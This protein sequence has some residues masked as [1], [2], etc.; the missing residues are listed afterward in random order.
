MKY[1]KFFHKKRKY[2][3]GDYVRL[4]R[5]KLSSDI[6]EINTIVKIVDVY[7]K[8]GDMTKYK[9]EG[10]L[11][12]KLIEYYVAEWQIKRKASEEE[13]E[14]FKFERDATKYNL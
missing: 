14:E 2:N 8:N 7:K 1:L 12:N 5:Y 3:I 11:D 13:I 9:I 6:E 4:I 10:L